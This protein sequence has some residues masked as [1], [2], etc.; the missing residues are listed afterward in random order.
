MTLLGISMAAVVIGLRV[1]NVI[2]NGHGKISN[3]P[4][5]T[6]FLSIGNPA[7]V[8]GFCKIGIDMSMALV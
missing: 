5:Q 2:G 8:I 6:A 4:R 7:V 1:F 3:G